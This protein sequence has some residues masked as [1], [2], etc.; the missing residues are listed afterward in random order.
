MI[1][2]HM[3]IRIKHMTTHSMVS[4]LQKTKQKPG[5]ADVE[6]WGGGDELAK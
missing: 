1:L 5:Q 6:A 2:P 4:N 3:Q